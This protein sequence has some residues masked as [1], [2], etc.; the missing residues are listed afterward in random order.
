VDSA[1]VETERERDL[2]LDNHRFRVVA[3]VAGVVCAP[4]VIGHLLLAT[5]G[6][7]SFQQ[8][9]DSMGGPLPAPTHLLLVLGRFGV[10][11]L[12]LVAFDVGIFAWMYRLAR[13]YWIGLLFAP[14]FV[15]LAASSVIGI[16]LY[17][18]LFNVV[19]LVK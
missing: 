10:L 19:S 12:L 16:L 1:A 7:A 3:A 11:A 18:P 14:I 15:Y 4:F 9:L 17:L 6:I 5:A 13:R 2:R 8:M